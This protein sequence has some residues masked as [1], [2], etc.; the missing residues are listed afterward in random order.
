M[1]HEYSLSLQHDLDATITEPMPFSGNGLDRFAQFGIINSLR[2]IPNR[3]AIHLQHITRP[4][5]ADAVGIAYMRHGFSLCAR[6]HHFFEFTSRSIALS[7]IFSANSFFS[8]CCSRLPK[9]AAFVH[10]KPLSRHTS[11]CI[12]KMLPARCRGDGKHLLSVRQTLALSRC[13]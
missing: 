4:T 2:P 11:I 12:C 6:R 9:L 10:P 7:S 1:V 8:A 5:L 3:R 13:Q